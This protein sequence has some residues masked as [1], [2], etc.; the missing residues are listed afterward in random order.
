MTLQ[1]MR[2]N[3]SDGNYAPAICDNTHPGLE[4]NTYKATVFPEGDI[5]GMTGGEFAVKNNVEYGSEPGQ[6]SH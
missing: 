6:L 3:T 2:Y 1:L 4:P 5:D